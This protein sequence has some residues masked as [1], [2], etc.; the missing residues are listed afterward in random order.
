[1]TP[2]VIPR[3]ATQEIPIIPLAVENT[4]AMSRHAAYWPNCVLKKCSNL[5]GAGRMYSQVI[6]KATDRRP[7]I[8]NI[9]KKIITS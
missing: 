1:M 3:R 6:L 7:S 2:S 4:M 5:V 8:D 9:A